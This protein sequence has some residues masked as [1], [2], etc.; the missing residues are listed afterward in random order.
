MPGR[1]L[2]DFPGF[3]KTSCS[4]HTFQHDQLIRV[5][6]GK[7]RCVRR[8]PRYK[9]NK[10]L[11]RSMAANIRLRLARLG[12]GIVAVPFEFNVLI[13]IVNRVIVVVCALQRP[14]E[15][16]ALPSLGRGKIAP[17]TIIQMPLADIALLVG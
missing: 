13:S 9:Q 17:S 14:P 7:V 12:D 1:Q 16:K 11:A 5:R 8:P 15:L 2:S 6:H 4:T 3:E 10:R